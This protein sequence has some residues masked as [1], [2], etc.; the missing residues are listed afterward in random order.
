MDLV[1]TLLT[2]GSIGLLGWLGFAVGSWVHARRSA[3][4]NPR[5]GYLRSFALSLLL[6]VLLGTIWFVA[7]G[8]IYGGLNL[9]PQVSGVYAGILTVLALVVDLGAVVLVPLVIGL[10]T[11]TQAKPNPGRTFLGGLALGAGAGIAFLLPP[12]VLFKLLVPTSACA[13]TNPPSCGSFYIGP[14]WFINNISYLVGWI[15]FQVGFTSAVAAGIGV[16]VAR[17]ADRR[18]REILSSGR[19]LSSSGAGDAA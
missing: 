2:G 1:P 9:V 11:G 4:I 14:N 15:A 8:M 3:G 5:G 19:R 6:F 12:I 16:L 7:T 10:L 17:L 13:E 18:P